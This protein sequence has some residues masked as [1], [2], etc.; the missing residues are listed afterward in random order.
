VSPSYGVR[1]TAPVAVATAQVELPF[2][3]TWI[4]GPRDI[5]SGPLQEFDTTAA[6]AVRLN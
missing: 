1:V 4:I 6:S 3:V 5:E 2:E